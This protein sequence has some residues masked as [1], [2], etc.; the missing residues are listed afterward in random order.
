MENERLRHEGGADRSN[1]YL[2]RLSEHSHGVGKMQYSKT[3]DENYSKLL[4]DIYL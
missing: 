3:I 2:S 1:I 4:K